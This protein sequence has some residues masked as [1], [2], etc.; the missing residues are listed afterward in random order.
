MYRQILFDFDG[1]IVDSLDLALRILNRM[2][3][4]YHYPTV[5]ESDMQ[6]LK[7][8]PL[9]ERFQKIGFPL[10][11]I[12]AMTVECAALYRR[13]IPGLKPVSGIL[14]LFDTL[15][16]EGCSLSV[17]SSNSEE[18]IAEFF[19]RNGIVQ[20]DH[21]FSSNNLF[22]KEKSIRKYLRRFGVKAEELLYVGDE[23]RDLDAC[24]AAGIK[25][26]AVTWG[27]DPLPLLRSGKPDF[28]AQAPAD[29]LGAVR[30]CFQ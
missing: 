24:R 14:D 19:R 4:K 22:G 6:L 8:M 13:E 5:T 9:T 7:S 3:E 16:T 30:S 21:I 20:F 1:T 18:N 11:K 23:L 26:V 12:P 17:L 27:Y 15:K 10:H 2:A 28:I 29:I 25:V